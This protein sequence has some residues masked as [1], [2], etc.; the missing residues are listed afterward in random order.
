MLYGFT[1]LCGRLVL[2]PFS[3]YKWEEKKDGRSTQRVPTFH[4]PQS[5]YV[6][7]PG[8]SCWTSLCLPSNAYKFPTVICLEAIRTLVPAHVGPTRSPALPGHSVSP[9]AC[10]LPF[11]LPFLIQLLF[12]PDSWNASAMP[13]GGHDLPS[14]KFPPVPASV[15]NVILLLD[16]TKLS[17]PSPPF[18]PRNGSF[19]PCSNTALI[20]QSWCLPYH[21]VLSHRDHCPSFLKSQPRIPGC[22][23]FRRSCIPIPCQYLGWAH[24]PSF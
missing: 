22:S 20:P 3:F 5:L 21:A 17:H 12:L 23:S 18:T 10:C 4:W 16:R 13:S 15:L 14:A 2:S 11:Y 1:A 8:R 7:A 24:C 6:G 19:F 9:R